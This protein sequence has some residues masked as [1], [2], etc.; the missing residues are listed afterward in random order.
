MCVCLSVCVNMFIPCLC[1]CLYVCVNMFIPYQAY[2]DDK[3]LAS[4]FVQVTTLLNKVIC[5]NYTCFKSLTRERDGHYCISSSKLD[6]LECLRDNVNNELFKMEKILLEGNI[7]ESYN[8]SLET[9][10][11]LLNI[12]AEPDD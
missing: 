5:S 10:T 3:A 9:D 11:K 7:K 1:V 8:L 4:A 6:V 12:I 2:L